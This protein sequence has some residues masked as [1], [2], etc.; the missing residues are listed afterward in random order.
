MI[1]EV[2]DLD[3]HDARNKAFEAAF[4]EAQR[5]IAAMPGYLAHELHQSIETPQRYMLLVR[6]R[7]V[8][9]HTVGFR[10]SMQYERWR[11][12]LQPFFVSTPVIGHFSLVTQAVPAD[13]P[14]AL[15]SHYQD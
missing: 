15:V 3:I 7:S 13:E 4:E 8:E 6:W 10:Q 12:L 5:I 2:A 14:G 1:L 11:A 9:D